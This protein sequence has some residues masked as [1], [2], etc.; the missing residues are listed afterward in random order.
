MRWFLIS[1][2]GMATWTGCSGDSP[3]T[4][5]V[6]VPEN[7]WN[8]GPMTAETPRLSVGLHNRRGDFEISP[9][10]IEGEFNNETEWELGPLRPGGQGRG[11]MIW[12]AQLPFKVP[13]AFAR[14]APPGMEVFA[15]GE[16][17][18]FS[19]APNGRPNTWRVQG[20]HLS[21]TLATKPEKVEVRYPS[22]A[23]D[24]SRLEFERSGLSTEEYV[25]FKAVQ[26][27]SSSDGLLLPAPSKGSWSL[28]LPETGASF[29]SRVGILPNVLEPSDGATVALVVTDANGDKHEVATRQLLGDRVDLSFWEVD[30]KDFN[31]Q[32]VEITIETRPGETNNGDYVFV[33]HP[34]IHGAAPDDIR[35]IV[36]IGIDTLRPDHMSLYGYRRNT[37]P[38]TDRWAANG[39]VFD[40]AWTNAPRTRPS[41]RSATTGQWPL[42]A[43]CAKNIGKVFQEHDWATAGIVS[44]VH[45]HSR[46]DFDDGFDWWRLNTKALAPEQVDNA[47]AWLSANQDRDSYLFLH[48]MDPHLF[49]RAPEPFRT[50]FDGELEFG[51]DDALPA[52]YNRWS[53]YQWKRYKQLDEKRQQTII[54]DYDA[55]IAFMDA[56]LQRLY[57]HLDS[58]PGQSLVIMHSDHGEELFDHG[59]FEH[60]HTLYDEVTKA[61]LVVRP[62]RGM[63]SVNKR[64]ALPASLVDIAPTA[65]EFA[66]ITEGVPD[67]LDGV[68]LLPAMNAT[69]PAAWDRIIPTAYLRYDSQ[70]WGTIW[71]NQ[72]YVV[73]TSTG[74]EMLFDLKNDPAE[75]ENLLEKQDHGID[76]TPWRERT[77]EIYDMPV[78]HGSRIRVSLTGTTPVHIE[79]PVPVSR[80]GVLDPEAITSHPANQAW[81]ETPAKTMVDVAASVTLSDDKRTVTFVPGSVGTG[82]LY[83]MH[84]P[85]DQP[86]RVKRYDE[87]LSP[88]A[89]DWT[90]GWRDF[91]EYIRMEQGV[92]VVPPIDE[93]PRIQQCHAGQGSASG[94]E[95]DLLR[96]LGYIGEEH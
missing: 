31:G 13:P 16:L 70:R 75:V 33:G 9:R 37:T 8:G 71:E 2:F 27:D 68:S 22:L 73:V 64:S 11:Q 20:K 42:E 38:H 25:H 32:R 50:M 67:D 28:R 23:K 96:K 74:E 19:V 29:R 36:V 95:I 7:P 24:L 82:V 72:K 57:K 66:G 94:A 40:N 84:E 10:N 56:Q 52:E 76:L 77:S 43:V 48:L 89:G 51:R 78:G 3:S 35:R 4:P 5:S 14:F 91:S 21:M 17:L 88:R 86:I 6:P 26:G 18:S 46:F 45:L 81:G 92:V 83:T 93:G 44:N 65:F 54:A 87:A 49:Y 34:A 62:P 63:S 61:V 1:M 30:L 41:F 47:M 60:N 80:A 59:G 39:V 53:V 79:F 12:R 85:T 69:E 90:R 15:D 58:L 55:E